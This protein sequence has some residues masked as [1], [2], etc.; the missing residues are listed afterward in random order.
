MNIEQVPAT[1]K[2]PISERH[3]L[4]S[5]ERHRRLKEFAVAYAF[6]LRQRTKN[7]EDIKGIQFL[8]ARSAGAGTESWH[9][10]SAYKTQ[11]AQSTR[12]MKEPVVIEELKRLGLE[13]DQSKGVWHDPQLRRSR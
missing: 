11:R 7:G 8:A 10:E 13:Y 9:P 5:E 6:L 2:A 3:R 12:W 1:P 4:R